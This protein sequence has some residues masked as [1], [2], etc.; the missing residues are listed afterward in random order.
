MTVGLVIHFIIP[1]L[2]FRTEVERGNSRRQ[3][4]QNV[5]FQKAEKTKGRKFKK[6]NLQEAELNKG[7]KKGH[8]LGK[9]NFCSLRSLRFTCPEPAYLGLS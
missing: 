8:V 2:I 1:G 7:R 6:R 9:A 3:N 4:L 5:E